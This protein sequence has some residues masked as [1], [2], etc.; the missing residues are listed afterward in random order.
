MSA[1]DLRVRCPIL[2]YPSCPAAVSSGSSLTNLVW[3]RR[4]ACQQAS[5]S[6]TPYGNLWFVSVSSMYK[7]KWTKSFAT[8][9]ELLGVEGVEGT[10]KLYL[11]DY[12][13]NVAGVQYIQGE[14]VR[15]CAGRNMPR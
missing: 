10:T 8:H 14:V 13:T 2:L 7:G 4:A 9:P 5:L 12:T 15:A 11:D 3:V 6:A 1:V